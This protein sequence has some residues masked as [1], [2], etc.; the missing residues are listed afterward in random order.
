MAGPVTAGLSLVEVLAPEGCLLCPGGTGANV[1]PL[2]SRTRILSSPGLL[3][4]DEL[5]LSANYGLHYIEP[6]G[7]IRRVSGRRAAHDVAGQ[8]AGDHR[9][10]PLQQDDARAYRRL[11][12]DYDEE[13]SAFSRSQFTPGGFGPSLDQSDRRDHPS[14]RI[15][16]RRTQQERRVGPAP[17]PWPRPRRGS[18]PRTLSGCP[19]PCRPRGARACGRN[20][21]GLGIRAWRGVGPTP[22]RRLVRRASGA[23]RGTGRALACGQSGDVPGSRE[24]SD[25]RRN[26]G[27]GRCL[28]RPGCRRR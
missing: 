27:R 2:V 6:A 26:G 4:R 17:R 19:L 9:D 25:P 18:P 7:R 3:T 16:H 11:L 1:C 22:P 28:V 24:E 15:H 8:G 10:P 21:P 12:A 20:H 23:S 14:R 5:G 13:K